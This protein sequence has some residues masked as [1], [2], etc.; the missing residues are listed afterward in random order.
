LLVDTEI[1][2]IKR[3]IAGN[4]N[5]SHTVIPTVYASILGGEVA[6][7]SCRPNEC[8]AVKHIGIGMSA[9]LVAMP[10]QD[11]VVRPKECTSSRVDRAENRFA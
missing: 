1:R 7:A 9:C 6:K 2:N 3:A 11:G 8:F 5:E 10:Y 4:F